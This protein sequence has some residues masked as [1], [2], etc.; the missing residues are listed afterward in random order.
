MA[1]ETAAIALAA[2][3]IQLSVLK[4]LGLNGV[5]DAQ[6]MSDIASDAGL[7]LEEQRGSSSTGKAEIDL[8]LQ[9]IS[10][11]VPGTAP[12]PGK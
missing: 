3:T 2:L 5:L 4:Q 10:M 1:N 9:M 8:A 7:S 11:L 6:D 12:K